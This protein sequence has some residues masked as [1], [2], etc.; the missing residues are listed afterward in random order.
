MFEQL[1]FFRRPRPE[2]GF[3][4]HCVADA[5]MLSVICC[6]FGPARQEIRI[7]QSCIA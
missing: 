2:T 1:P 4:L 5:A 3:D 6:G 7:V